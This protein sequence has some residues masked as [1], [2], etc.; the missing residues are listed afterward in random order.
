MRNV[1]KKPYLLPF[2][3]LLALL[4]ASCSASA[5]DVALHQAV[6]ANNPQ[7]VQR[8]LNDGADVNAPEPDEISVLHD[9]ATVIIIAAGKEYV[10]VVEIL[11]TNG[12]N[13]NATSIYGTTAL[14][15]AASQGNNQIVNLLL[16]AGAAIDNSQTASKTPLMWAAAFDQ[17][18]TVELLLERGAN[19]SLTNE[20]GLT[21]LDFALEGGHEEVVALLEALENGH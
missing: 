11:I 12:A 21:A 9:Q 6:R 19:P 1:Y 2:I 17:P 4:L 13:V 8:L 20:D 10:E 15:E 16:D 3:L 7:E 5:E 18:H 14:G